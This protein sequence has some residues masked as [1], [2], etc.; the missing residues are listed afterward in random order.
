MVAEGRRWRGCVGSGPGQLDASALE[1]QA[2]GRKTVRTFYEILAQPDRLPRGNSFVLGY[3]SAN[4]YGFNSVVVE[5]DRARRVVVVLTNAGGIRAER[6]ANRID[7]L[8]F[9]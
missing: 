6:L 3:A 5:G 4:D 1:R 9:P 7:P 8:V 2:L